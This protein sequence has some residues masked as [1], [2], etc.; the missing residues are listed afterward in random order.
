M[1][2]YDE[3]RIPRKLAVPSHQ[4]DIRA[5]VMRA[6]VPPELQEA[7]TQ[8]LNDVQNQQAEALR[9]AMLE[10]ERYVQRLAPPDIVASAPGSFVAGITSPWR[11][12]RSGSVAKYLLSLDTAGTSDTDVDL[13]VDGT[14]VA[15]L[16]LASGD[17]DVEVT[18]IPNVAI[19]LSSRVQFEITTVGSGASGLTAAVWI[20]L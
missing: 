6:N 16:T 7:L 1:P 3:F 12:R 14:A 8:V 17:T 19:A 4:R 11:A 13:I 20:G 15:T 9:Q 2:S 18:N 10:I 5:A